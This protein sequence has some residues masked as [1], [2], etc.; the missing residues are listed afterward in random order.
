MSK[1]A[2]KNSK[3]LLFGDYEDSHHIAKKAKQ[4]KKKQPR[5]FE[6]ALRAK[7]LKRILS[8]EEAI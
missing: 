6:N 2:R 5:N 7:D 4:T 1:T 3:Q 8:Y